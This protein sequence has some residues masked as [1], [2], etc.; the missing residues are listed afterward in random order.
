VRIALLVLIAC[1]PPPAAKPEQTPTLEERVRA[2]GVVVETFFDAKLAPYDVVIVPTHAAMVEVA[3]AK[4]RATEL[5][6]FAV[7]MGTGS[8]LLL[9]DPAAWKTEACDHGSDGPAEVDRVIVHELVHVLHGQQRPADRE[10]ANADAVGWFVEGLAT[11]AADQLGP[12]RMQALRASK[13]ADKLDDVWTGKTRYAA[14]GTLVRFVDRRIG[15][16]KLRALLPLST[17]AEILAAI[18]MTEAELLA[19]WQGALRESGE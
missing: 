5:P 11:Y 6:C 4:W 17:N 19:A 8:T 7:A 18:G 16:A 15:R 13:L 12:A 3:T 10:L 1:S 14:A 9:L 2:H